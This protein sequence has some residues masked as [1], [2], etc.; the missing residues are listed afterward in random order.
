MGYNFKA[1]MAKIPFSTE[2]SCVQEC[3]VTSKVTFNNLFKS[4]SFNWFLPVW[5]Q[6]F[7]ATAGT[8]LPA[9]SNYDI[10]KK[11]WVTGTGTEH[12]YHKLTQQAIWN[13]EKWCRLCSPA[14]C[15]RI[16]ISQNV[17]M[18]EFTEKTRKLLLACSHSILMSL[19]F[20]VL[21]NVLV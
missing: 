21:T 9:C 10:G 13:H 6:R 2:I 8:H 20:V 14:Q 15:V 7:C 18:P 12:H 5:N 16:T 19:I 1:V 4:L 11:V 17:E 3:I